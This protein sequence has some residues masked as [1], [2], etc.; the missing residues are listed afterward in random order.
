[1]LAGLVRHQPLLAV[2]VA[3]VAGLGSTEL[4]IS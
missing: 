3:A 1:M 2:E 4:P